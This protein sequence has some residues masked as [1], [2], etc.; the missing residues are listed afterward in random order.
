[1]AEHFYEPNVCICILDTM[2][3]GQT[4]VYPQP[5]CFGDSYFQEPK[6]LAH[7]TIKNENEPCFKLVSFENLVKHGLFQFLPKLEAWKADVHMWDK[8]SSLRRSFFKEPRSISLQ[9]LVKAKEIATLFGEDLIL[10]VT[11]ALLSLIRRQKQDWDHFREML[12]WT[13]LVIPEGPLVSRKFLFD[14]DTQHGAKEL[15]DVW[16]FTKVLED[17]C[18]H[19]YPTE[20]EEELQKLL[21]RE[22]EEQSGKSEQPRLSEQSDDEEDAFEN[23]VNSL[24]C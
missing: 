2:K 8:L 18:G 20:H 6:Y 23:G 21:A 1:M 10:P 3:V 7:G 12:K 9:E 5:S 19:V 24:S 11:V 13:D 16:Q 17:I 15:P 14:Q 22:L 4:G